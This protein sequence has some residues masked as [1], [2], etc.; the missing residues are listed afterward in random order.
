MPNLPF[1]RY[2][3]LVSVI[4]SVPMPWG[5]A[6]TTV[7]LNKG[8]PWLTLL[9]T[10]ATDRS[11][12]SDQMDALSREFSLLLIDM[13]G[14]GDSTAVP[15]P[16][17]IAELAS[18]VVAIW[19]ALEVNASLVAGL[20]I[21]GM[22][23]LCLA[24]EHPDRVTALM[25]GGCR[26]QTSDQFRGMWQARRDVLATGGMDAIVDATIPTWFPPESVEADPAL[27]E[28]VG[29][30]I[31]R[32]SALG[33]VGATQALEE[34]NLFNRLSAISVPSLLLV[35]DKDGAHPGEMAR[36]KDQI[37]HSKLVTIAGAGH[38][39]N[40]DQPAQFMAA[41]MPFLIENGVDNGE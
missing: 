41:I 24:S 26:A 12:W 9:H 17:S 15:P 33:Y 21:G 22:I 5:E 28:R 23:A 7:V 25:A 3:D 37:Q 29:R 18:D 1:P 31:G 2:P 13:R 32:T 36:M 38:L 34:L 8:K 19:D 14:H 11:L 35:G 6:A 30:M 10:L 27:P 16:Y 39:P 40:L 4:L 20:S